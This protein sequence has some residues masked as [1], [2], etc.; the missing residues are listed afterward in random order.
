VAGLDPAIYELQQ[1]YRFPW[2]PGSRP[3]MNDWG[4]T[5]FVEMPG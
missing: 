3:G 4:D 2:M 1:P 5:R